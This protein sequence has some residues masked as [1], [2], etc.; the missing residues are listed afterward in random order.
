MNHTLNP[1]SSNADDEVL[2]RRIR[3]EL[4][5]LKSLSRLVCKPE[6]LRRLSQD[7]LD[8][9]MASGIDA[10]DWWEANRKIQE[11]GNV[12]GLF[13]SASLANQYALYH[14]VRLI[15]AQSVLEIGT[16]VGCSAGYLSLALQEN[17]KNHESTKA[18]LTTVDIVD[19]NDPQ[20][21]RW[22]EV[23]SPLPPVEFIR[24]IGCA[25][26]TEFVVS[27]SLDYMSSTNEV[28]D[29]IFLDGLHRA[30]TVYR[31][32]PASL[33]RLSDGGIIVLHD[34]YPECKPL[35]SAQLP[36]G[37]KPG[38]YLGVR[39]LIEHGATFQVLPLGAVPTRTGGEQT[40][41]IAVVVAGGASI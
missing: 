41:S 33:E 27:D 19:V 4:K 24:K 20:I 30:S 5:G 8:K 25:D 17:S 7:E 36:S 18:R 1:V 23:G 6:P 3:K 38:P 15:R 10:D 26:V 12:P 13:S 40:L 35:S 14:L 37:V 2:S 29:L 28:Y 32:I 34:Y 9:A 39:R 16:N 21:A 31:E 22:E 11:T